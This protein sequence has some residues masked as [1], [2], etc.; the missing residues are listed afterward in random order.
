M[1]DATMEAQFS[2]SSSKTILI[3]PQKV[4]IT[5]ALVWAAI[6]FFGTISEISKFYF[7]HYL[8][9]FKAFDLDGEMNMP[10]IFS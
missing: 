2:N 8:P 3:S 7:A 5:F 1:K 9:L 10:A 4:A 6:V